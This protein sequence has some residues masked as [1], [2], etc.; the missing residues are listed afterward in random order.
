M[1]QKADAVLALVNEGFKSY[2]LISY[3]TCTCFVGQRPVDGNQSLTHV[4]LLLIELI[5][6]AHKRIK[7]RRQMVITSFTTMVKLTMTILMMMTSKCNLLRT[8]KARA[9]QQ[10]LSVVWLS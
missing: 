3:L 10:N 4:H 9:S 6:G 8:C 2:V 7:N 5:K 1:R